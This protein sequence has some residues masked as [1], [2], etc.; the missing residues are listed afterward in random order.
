MLFLDEF[1]EFSRVVLENLRQPLEDGCVTVSRAQ[2]TVT[3]PARFLMIAAMNPCP[4][5]FA[6]DPDRACTCT[7]S[8]LQ[9]YAK[10]L[11]GPMLDRIDL[12]IEVPKV[13]TEKLTNL[14]PGEPSASIRERVQAARDLQ[15]QRYQGTSLVTNAELTSE[16]VRNL[17]T[18]QPAA[19]KLLNLAVDRYRLSA[20]AYFRVLKVS[21]TI[22]DL[23][24]AD[25]VQENHVG[26]ALRYRKTVET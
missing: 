11:S 1:P 19:R 5:G 13:P 15:T 21:R 22:A 26:E 2:G 25:I 3:F 17:I 23:E 14:E 24:Q 6:T 18:L 4:C 9:R 10:R 7:P 12:S 8:Q 20:R 16:Q